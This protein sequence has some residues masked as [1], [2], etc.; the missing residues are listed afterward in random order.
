MVRR[1]NGKIMNKINEMIRWKKKL[2][3]WTMQLNLFKIGKNI[4]CL[5]LPTIQ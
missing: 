2:Y 3:V 1:L 4:V 5:N